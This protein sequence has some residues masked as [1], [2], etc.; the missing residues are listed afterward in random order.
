LS[1]YILF[2]T[3]ESRQGVDN[4]NYMTQIRT[5]FPKIV[6]N[7]R[8][9]LVKEAYLKGYTQQEVAVIFNLSRQQIGNILT[10]RKVYIPKK[11]QNEK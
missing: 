10:E 6:K 11:E 7:Y 3:I 9:F 1:L 4:L 5:T 2:A 8:D